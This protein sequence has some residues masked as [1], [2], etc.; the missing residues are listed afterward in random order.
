[1]PGKIVKT[2]TISGILANFEIIEGVPDFG[3]S[4]EMIPASTL[5]DTVKQRRAHPMPEYKDMVFKVAD[6]GTKPTTSATGVKVTI[7]ATDESGASIASREVMAVISDVTPE[8]VA[9]DGNRVPA[10][11]VTISPTGETVPQT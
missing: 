6:K 8:T 3:E 2:L 9:V 10:Y 5:S 11:S 4:R 7:A 1:M